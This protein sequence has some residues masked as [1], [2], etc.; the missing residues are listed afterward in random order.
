MFGDAIADIRRAVH[1]IVK[2]ESAHDGSVFFDEDVEGTGPRFLFGQELTVP[3]RELLEEL[4]ATI[5]NRLGE[6]RCGS[7]VQS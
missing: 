2:V 1:K 4:I 5:A 7:T 6:A 3:L